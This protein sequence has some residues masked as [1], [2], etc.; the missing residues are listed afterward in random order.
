MWA[1]LIAVGSEL[2]SWDKAETNSLYISKQL[3]LLGINVRF[4]SIVGDAE[5][6]IEAVLKAAVSRSQVVIITG[7]LG[8]TEDDLT[9]KAVAKALKRG[10]VLKEELIEK[11]KK[12]FESMGKAMPKNNERQA[13]MPNKAVVIDNPIGTA[14]GFAIE[15][16]KVLIICLPGVPAEMQRMFEEGAVPLIKKRIDVS[17]AVRLWIIRTC[18]I[19]EAKVDELIGDLYAAD[20][21]IR[22][23]LAA[24]EKGVDV[25]I[26]SSKASE[27]ETSRLSA[28]LEEK[29]TAILKDYIYGFDNEEMEEI[30]VRLLMEKGA[31]LAVAESCTG[32]LISKRLT[33]VSG[34][35]A[36]FDRG[37]VSYSNE[38]KIQMLKISNDLIKAYGAVSSQVAMAM[39]ESVRRISNTELGIGVTGIAGPTG[40][41]P[42]KPVGLV[43]IAISEKGKET[44]C[45]GYNFA[46]NRGM[47]R[48]KAS[49]FALNIIRRALLNIQ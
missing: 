9:R 46:G 47:I 35:S 25:R 2:L 7:G 34:S 3:N 48:M 23:G 5:S 17:E 24:G 41:T 4:K 11:I 36:C 49:Q 44:R 21:N 42:E 13:L 1:E 10:L 20:K 18:G 22:I 33:D 39:A 43:Y 29:I 15:H 12:R 37:I 31:K 38:A 32:G 28:E 19:A 6:D 45:K 30:V 27:I 8:P 14:P 40:G 16:D 26:T